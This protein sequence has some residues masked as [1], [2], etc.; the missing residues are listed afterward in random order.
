VRLIVII[1]TTIIVGILSCLTIAIYVSNVEKAYG[2]FFYA[3]IMILGNIILPVFL[4]VC[5]YGFLKGQIKL[6]NKL[7]RYFTQV[8]LIILLS[9][10]GLCFMTVSKVVSYYSGFSGMTIQNLEGSFNSSYRGY[11]PE[12]ILYSF[13]IPFVYRLL[14]LKIIKSTVRQEL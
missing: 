1:L 5:L 12:V 6:S 3:F 10:F 7:A 2:V 14:E 9:A 8:G 11:V 13:L 4:I